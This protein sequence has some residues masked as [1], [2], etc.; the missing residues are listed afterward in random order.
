ML[1]AIHVSDY[2]LFCYNIFPVESLPYIYIY[3]CIPCGSS[4][5]DGVHALGK[6][7]LCSTQSLRNLPSVAFETI[8]VFTSWTVASSGPSKEDH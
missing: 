3:V 2:L 1:A 6:A 8:P 7:H 4:V 5:Q